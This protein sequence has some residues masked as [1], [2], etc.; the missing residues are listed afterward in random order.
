MTSDLNML[1]SFL[2]LDDEIECNNGDKLWKELKTIDLKDRL[3]KG[4]YENI[5][6]VSFS[7]LMCC[8]QRNDI[9]K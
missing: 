4:T 9:F 8:L 3:F 1:L 2:N 7:N 6:E 5:S